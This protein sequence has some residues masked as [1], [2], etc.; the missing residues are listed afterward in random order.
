MSF[1]GKTLI[2][3]Q[4]GKL[5]NAVEPK[6]VNG[7]EILDKYVGESEKKVQHISS[8]CTCNAFCA[9]VV[10][11]LPLQMSA[12]LL[13]GKWSSQWCCIGMSLLSVLACCCAFELT[14]QRMNIVKEPRACPACALRTC[15]GVCICVLSTYLPVHEKGIAMASMSF[16][17][18][19]ECTAG[20]QCAHYRTC[21]LLV[22]TMQ[23]GTRI[24]MPAFA[25]ALHVATYQGTLRT[26]Q[27][28]CR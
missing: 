11:F 7:P 9:T 24:C 26:L 1:A 16:N 27:R 8:H 2:A 21:Q 14:M 23:H 4:I 10:F 25:P 22:S 28:R 17:A 20:R 12:A 15:R 19:F 13:G 18:A 6:V 5:L 3:R